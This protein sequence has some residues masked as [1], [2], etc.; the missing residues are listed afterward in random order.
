Q[1]VA[2]LCE[3]LRDGGSWKG[4][5]LLHTARGERVTEWRVT[6]YREPGEGL[7]YVEDQTEHHVRERAQRLQLDSATS[8]LAV[9]IAERERTEM[10]LQQALKMDALGK[11]T[12][13][14]AHD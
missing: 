3:A 5:F 8:E 9:Q 13:G 12:G 6:P 4:T 14:I 7:L 2:A 10:E 11:L 1:P